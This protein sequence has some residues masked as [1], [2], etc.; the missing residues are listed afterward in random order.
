ME[1]K[2]SAGDLP[3]LVV[4]EYPSIGQ[5]WIGLHSPTVPPE[6]SLR[7]VYALIIDIRR[8]VTELVEKSRRQSWWMRLRARLRSILEHYG[9][10]RPQ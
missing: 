5:P 9:I 4:T 1:N 2:A 10:S 8:D 6:P 7:D 3:V